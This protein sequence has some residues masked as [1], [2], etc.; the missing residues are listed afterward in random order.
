MILY[1]FTSFL[2]LLQTFFKV[3][4]VFKSC[5]ALL[6]LNYCCIW[7]LFGL[8]SLPTSCVHKYSFFSKTLVA[9]ET[10]WSR[11]FFN[12]LW[13]LSR[14]ARSSKE[15]VDIQRQKVHKIKM[16]EWFVWINMCPHKKKNYAM[17][18]WHNQLFFAKCSKE[19]KNAF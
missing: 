2:Q 15:L 6:F 9:F 5:C 1:F 10:S 3:L 12:C 17:N 14:S 13:S 8:E 19:G 7:N 11:V 4:F 16:N 18:P